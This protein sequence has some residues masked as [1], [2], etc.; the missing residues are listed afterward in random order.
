[1]VSDG[2]TLEIY[3]EF[4]LLWPRS[5]SVVFMRQRGVTTLHTRGGVLMALC[6][7][8][9]VAG[10]VSQSRLSTV[11]GFYCL[12]IVTA[13]VSQTQTSSGS[14]HHESTVTMHCIA[15]YWNV[16]DY[17]GEQD[18]TRDLSTDPS[19]PLPERG[20]GDRSQEHH[21]GHGEVRDQL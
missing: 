10:F 5:H 8:G 7:W 18:E 20:P 1:M 3:R 19:W 17:I 6:C 4:W 15:I 13:P 14:Q 11:I 16:S 2:F 9:V 21:R 12:N